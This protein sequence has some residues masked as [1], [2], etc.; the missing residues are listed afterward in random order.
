V[1][2]ELRRIENDIDCFPLLE[3]LT[4][5]AE[6]EAAGR[7]EF[8]EWEGPPDPDE[9]ADGP[10]GLDWLVVVVAV[11]VT[12]G[13]AGSLRNENVYTLAERWCRGSTTVTVTAFWPWAT[14]NGTES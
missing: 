11:V 9:P 2:A 7:C 8:V 4:A 3:V 12:E 6:T 13:V 5:G 10:A 14:L 1:A